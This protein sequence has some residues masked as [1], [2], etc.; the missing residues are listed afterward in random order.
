MAICEL[1][2]MPGEEMWWVD[3]V[4]GFS[5]GWGYDKNEAIKRAIHYIEENAQKSHIQAEL[6]Y[7]RDEE[8]AYLNSLME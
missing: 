8:I 1:K 6:W 3:G 4:S 2:N 5:I 7:N